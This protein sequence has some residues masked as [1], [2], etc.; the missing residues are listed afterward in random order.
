MKRPTLICH[1][2]QSINGKIA[3][4]FYEAEMIP[5]GGAL[6][7]KLSEQF[8]A[9]A[10]LYGRITAE[11]LFTAGN[12]LKLVPG[13][14]QK[15]VYHGKKADHYVVVLD[16]HA[17][18]AWNERSLNAPRLKNKGVITIVSEQVDD[19][20]LRGLETLGISYVV[21]NEMDKTLNVLYET[22]GIEKMLVQGGGIINASLVEL[23]MI[24]EISLVIV[25]VVALDQAQTCFIETKGY[26]PKESLETFTHVHAHTID[27]GIVWLHYEK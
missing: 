11:E 7:R 26:S 6:Y 24:D 15:P 22:F 17:K 23:G 13:I 8:D 25:P 9:D 2:M 5:Q 21:S 12:S 1:M 3:G 14:A 20:Y 10:I 16:P 18:L 19:S 27:D 4:N